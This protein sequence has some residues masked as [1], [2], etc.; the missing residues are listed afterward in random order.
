MNQSV[1]IGGLKHQEPATSS[2][3]QQQ[4]LL[5]EV[6]VHWLGVL[7]LQQMACS[8]DDR[9]KIQA[10]EGGAW[11][12]LWTWDWDVDM[13]QERVPQTTLVYRGSILGKFLVKFRKFWNI[14]GGSLTSTGLFH[15]RNHD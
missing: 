9:W 5:E 1:G 3:N 4:K 14:S 11:N 8:G 2:W 10:E 15:Y 12:G 13:D 6:W 7:R